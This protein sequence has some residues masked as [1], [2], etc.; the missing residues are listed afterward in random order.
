M[1]GICEAVR[2]CSNVFGSM[3]DAQEINRFDSCRGPRFVCIT[4]PIILR[5]L[6]DRSWFPT[7]RPIAASTWSDFTE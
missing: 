7:L 5:K 3:I 1:N 4:A 2:A 6:D